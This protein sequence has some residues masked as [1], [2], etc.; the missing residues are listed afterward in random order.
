MDNRILKVGVEINGELLVYSGANIVAKINKSTDSKQNSCEVVISNLLKSTIDYLVTESS[1]WNPSP[2]PKLLT[3]IAGRDS[4]G[5][6][7]IFIGDI[8]NAIPTM[9]PDRNLTLKANTQDGAKYKWTSRS[10]PRTIQL[11]KLCDGIARDYNL[12][13]KFEATDKTISNYVFN[14]P[15]A[16]QVK[17]LELVG[18]I[19][20]Y[21]DDEVLVVKDFGKGLKGVVPLI[22]S[23]TCMIGTPSVDD[24][25]V[26]VRILFDP[27]FK[28]GDQVE[29][30]SEV[31]PSINGQYVIYNMAYSLANRSVEWYIDL[32]CNNDNIKSIAAKREASR[33]KDAKSK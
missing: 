6:D 31:N 12:R 10:S 7:R 22:A 21:I 2:N 15:L 33:K 14:G 20:C 13:L 23:T 27:N 28:L 11:S 29:I 30:R 32:S 9:P 8:T 19:D 17:K 26:K 16:K 5:E 18:D 25:G 3:I 24:K 1:P 4:T